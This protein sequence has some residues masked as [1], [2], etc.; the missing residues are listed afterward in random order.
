MPCAGP[1][2]PNKTYHTPRPRDSN[3]MR[4][5]LKNGYT[6]PEASVLIRQQ[7]LS[8]RYHFIFDEDDGEAER[9]EIRFECREREFLEKEHEQESRE[10]AAAIERVQR[11]NP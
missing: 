10:M 3:I 8:T 7:T 2:I 11:R 4:Q 9:V 5:Y 6:R 1:Y